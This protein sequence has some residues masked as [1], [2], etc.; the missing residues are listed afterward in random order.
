LN[1]SDD[2]YAVDEQPAEASASAEAN[3]GGFDRVED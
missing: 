2:G 3:A 1:G